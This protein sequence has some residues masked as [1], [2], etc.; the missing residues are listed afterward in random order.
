[1]TIVDIRETSLWRIWIR[2][3]T[4]TLLCLFMMVISHQDS[5]AGT[6]PGHAQLLCSDCHTMHYSVR[7][8]APPGAVPG[9]PFVELL[10]TQTTN[11]LCLSCHDGSDP[12]APDV[13]DAVG[14]KPAG[15]YFS[16]GGIVV[17]GNRHSLGSSD[18]PPGYTGGTW[19]E[20][21]TCTSC[22]EPHENED[23]RNL[24][25]NP[26]GVRPSG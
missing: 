7:G 9:G 26:G 12:D 15:G 8:T 21:L 23:Y 2:C 11:Q 6:E 1:M 14:Y 22:H 20:V 24:V 5:M 16:P 10:L 4:R 25:E 17:E 18:E 3:T 13:E 19:S